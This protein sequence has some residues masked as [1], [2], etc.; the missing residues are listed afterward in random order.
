MHIKINKLII[1]TIYHR[2]IR[3]LHWHWPQSLHLNVATVPRLRGDRFLLNPWI[4]SFTNHS[5]KENI[6]HTLIDWGRCKTKCTHLHPLSQI[7]FS[8]LLT[9]LNSNY[10]TANFRKKSGSTAFCKGRKW[11]MLSG[12]T[13]ISVIPIAFDKNVRYKSN[14]GSMTSGTLTWNKHKNY[15]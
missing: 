5:T 4:S 15:K 3:Q 11:C 2:E 10:F 13:L 12:P 14:R 7:N 1:C 6:P 8:K 9:L